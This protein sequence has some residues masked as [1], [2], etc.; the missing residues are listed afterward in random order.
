MKIDEKCMSPRIRQS[1]YNYFVLGR[2]SIR[3][4]SCITKNST[5]IGSNSKQWLTFPPKCLW[6]WIFASQCYQ[7]LWLLGCFSSTTLSVGFLSSCLW[8]HSPKTAAVATGII[9]ACKGERESSPTQLHP[10]AGSPWPT[11]LVLTD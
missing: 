10:Q 9:S 2:G 5:N 3:L 6:K 8:T 1:F 7:V 11:P 4:C